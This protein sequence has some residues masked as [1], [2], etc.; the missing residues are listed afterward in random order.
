MSNDSNTIKYQRENERIDR[1]R[2][3]P[4]TMPDF[5]LSDY[6]LYIQIYYRFT[7]PYRQNKW[8][9]RIFTDLLLW[10]DALKHNELLNRDN[11]KKYLEQLIEDRYT[12][13]PLNIVLK[14]EKLL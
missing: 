3:E 11:L 2:G 10:H 1:L 9:D 13:P 7:L 5:S 8:S 4:F 12:R 6:D 14:V